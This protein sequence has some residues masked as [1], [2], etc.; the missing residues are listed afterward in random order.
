MKTKIGTLL[1]SGSRPERLPPALPGLCFL[2]SPLPVEHHWHHPVAPMTPT[3]VPRKAQKAQCYQ[4]SLKY[5]SDMTDPLLS[6]TTCLVSFHSHC[7]SRYR[8]FCIHLADRNTEASSCVKTLLIVG[9]LAGTGAGH[10]TL[11]LTQLHTL[12]L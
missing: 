9:K 5:Q 4:P 8:G 6:L 10:S 1:F 7:S 3:S 2:P 11:P 12:S